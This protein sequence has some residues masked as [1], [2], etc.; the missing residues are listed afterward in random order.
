VDLLEDSDVVLANDSGP[1]HVAM[2]VGTA[3]VGVFWAPNMINAAPVG[4]RRHRVH[5]GWTVHCPRCGAPLAAGDELRCAHEESW[6]LDVRVE[7][8]LADVLEL[9]ETPPVPG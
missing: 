5:P 9:L 8:V 4:R 3:T 2:A 7:P 6:V 1:R